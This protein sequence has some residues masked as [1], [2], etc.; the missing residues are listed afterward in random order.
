[1][2]MLTAGCVL[3]KLFGGARKALLANHSL[4]HLQRC[5]IHDSPLKKRFPLYK[6]DLSQLQPL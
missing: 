4:K 1:M 2:E 3:I 5:Q 6:R